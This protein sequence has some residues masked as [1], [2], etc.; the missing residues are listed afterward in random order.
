MSLRTT[1]LY[2]LCHDSSRIKEMYIQLTLLVYLTYIFI[3]III[4]NT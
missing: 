1:K 2:N 3:I 4:Y